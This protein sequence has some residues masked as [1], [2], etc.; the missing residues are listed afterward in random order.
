[1][2]LDLDVERL[3]IYNLMPA[4]VTKANGVAL[5]K[6]IRN[7]KKENCIALGDSLE[8][9]KMA[10]EVQYFFLMKNALDHREELGD[11]LTEI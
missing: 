10:P 5:D 3:H 7:F 8:D 6:K 9:L 2:E 1:M 4:G 11:E